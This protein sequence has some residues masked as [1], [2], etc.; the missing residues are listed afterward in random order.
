MLTEARHSHPFVVRH[1]T[2]QPS[3]DYLDAHPSPAR[4][5]HPL[6]PA[7]ADARP[8]GFGPGRDALT[9]VRTLVLRHAEQADWIPLPPNT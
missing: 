5:D 3:S 9:T 6:P 7:P 2:H 8:V 1:G 4:L